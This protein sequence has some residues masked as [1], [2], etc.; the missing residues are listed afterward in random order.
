MTSVHH[1][2]P[3]PKGALTL[4]ISLALF[5]L[6]VTAGVRIFGI[7]P[8]A[9]PVALRAE[10]K[11]AAIQSRDLRFLDQPNGSVLILDVTSGKA[12]SVIE[13]G[14]QS[15]FIRGVMRGLARDRM[16]RGI[17]S[18]APFRLTEWA[19][20]ELSLTD[21]ATGRTLEMTAFGTT[22]RAAFA[23]LLPSAAA[24]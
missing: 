24:K 17:G 8:S 1:H 19:D 6:A 20:G 21:S 22:N 3:I 15:G 13:P 4:A 7:P 18:E 14:S 16:K 23:A 5:A 11:V 2:E 10:G 12:A 9:S